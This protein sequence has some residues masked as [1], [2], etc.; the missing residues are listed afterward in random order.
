[1]DCWQCCTNNYNA[2]RT[3]LWLMSI[4]TIKPKMDPNIIPPFDDDEGEAA[5]MQQVR[6]F[7]LLSRC[8]LRVLFT[9]PNIV[10][11]LYSE[12]W[13]VLIFRA[14]LLLMSN[15]SKG[16]KCCIEKCSGCLPGL[17]AVQTSLRQKKNRYASKCTSLWESVTG[18]S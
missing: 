9:I 10:P 2:K 16:L 12:Q 11:T 15:V 4:A 13:I 5:S 14:T 1:M 6:P 7:P 18:K 8:C 17:S 3:L